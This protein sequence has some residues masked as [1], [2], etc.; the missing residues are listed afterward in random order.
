MGIQETQKGPWWSLGSPAPQEPPSLSLPLFPY[1]F[2]TGL[3]LSSTSSF[4]V[5]T[6]CPRRTVSLADVAVIN[7]EFIW[8]FVKL[9]KSANVLGH[10]G[11]PSQKRIHPGFIP[12]FSSEGS[13]PALSI[14]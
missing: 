10:T 4:L 2:H 1:G 3:C 6:G 7:F 11:A 5:P 9:V 8:Q 13:A 12:S 14:T